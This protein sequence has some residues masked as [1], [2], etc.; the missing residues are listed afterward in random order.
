MDLREGLM[1]E[2]QKRELKRMKFEGDFIP[3]VDTSGEGAR[4]ANALE[5]IAFQLGQI[6][7]KLDKSED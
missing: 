4:I 7:R 3:L 6:N 5:Y 1:D 2:K